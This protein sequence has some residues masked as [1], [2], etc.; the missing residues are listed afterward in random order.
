MPAREMVDLVDDRDRVIGSANLRDCLE[1]G[2]LHRA[3]AVIV[4]R[5][6]G[7]IL[8]QRRSTA[9]VWNP[10]LWTLS[11]TGH[12]RKDESYRKAA[13]RELREELGLESRLRVLWKV[14]LPP[15]RDRLLIE[16]EWV[17][18]FV[19]RTEAEPN[20][21]PAEL[22]G[23]KEATR[24]E[25][26]KLAKLGRLTDDARIIIGRYLETASGWNRT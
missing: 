3:V 12:V 11:C 6:N 25:L 22:S 1:K 16:H 9:D 15:I 10:G 8:L 24:A 26:L 13:S 18:V 5:S 19:T 4:E 7:S 2:L 20:P 23:V 21:D 17:S 14:R